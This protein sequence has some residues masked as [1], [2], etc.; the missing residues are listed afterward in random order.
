M[1]T[2]EQPNAPTVPR[3]VGGP[4]LY[5][6]KS[7]GLVRE[8]GLR[9]ALAINL[10]GVSLGSIV[11]GF[12][13]AL[14]TFQNANLTLPIIIGALILV[15]MILV[16]GQLTA[17]MPRTGGDYVF[18]G[19]ILHPAL[20]AAAGFAMLVAIGYS[21]GFTATWI[22]STYGPPSILA[23][24]SAF[25]ANWSSAATWL[26]TH[27]GM[28]W[29]GLPVILLAVVVGLRGGGRALARG[30][31][32]CIALGML[33]II[34][35][36]ATFFL[37]STPDFRSAFN[38]AALKPGAYGGIIAAAHAGG[39]ST[40]TTTSGIIAVLPF[41]V[42]LYLG[43]TYAVYPAGEVRSPGRTVR[44]S[45]LGAVGIS[46][47]VF[48]LAWLGL[49]HM[50][51]LPFAQAS[52]W[53]GTNDPAAAAKLT[54]LPLTPNGYAFLM[55][56]GG[57]AVPKILLALLPLWVVAVEFVGVLVCSRLM[58]ALSFDRLL[59]S[60]VSSVSDR[61]RSPVVAVCATGVIL[62]ASMV[63][64]IYT[65]IGQAFTNVVLIFVGVMFVSSIA[66]T[67]F[68]W[69]KK[70]L[71]A[72]SPKPYGASW[73]GIPPVT[74]I[75]A[76]STVLLGYVFYLT[77]TKPQLSGPY[78]PLSVAVLLCAAFGGIV[79]YGVSKLYLRRKGTDLGLALRE[80]PPE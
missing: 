6:R 68:P 63:A 56:G 46:L 40:G 39:W 73:F 45:L 23:L 78:K 76:V 62:F 13:A 14:A 3:D 60:A 47:L 31:L 11:I 51:G 18:Q 41:A 53:V 9:D 75:G 74:V 71:Y 58:F 7:S 50:V 80:L 66:G 44:R 27:G 36:I 24:G 20:G 57:N 59:P 37:N 8:I 67:L 2:V 79:A 72:A 52:S 65:G 28:F 17:A 34:V 25:G 49:V 15:P 33:S 1:E 35:M 30:Q 48:L 19:R 54:S 5:T 43:F 12:S 16:Y 61:T 22:G 64:G 26:T 38:A 70:D 21:V 32:I 77:L 42:L 10:S 29:T 55:L 69:I 4:G